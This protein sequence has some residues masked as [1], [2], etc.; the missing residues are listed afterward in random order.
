MHCAKIDTRKP[1]L[2]KQLT[3]TISMETFY[4]E[5]AVDHVF[6]TTEKDTRREQRFAFLR[7]VRA[8][9]A[10]VLGVKRADWMCD[11][12]AGK[13]LRESARERGTNV[14]TEQRNWKSRCKKLAA[15]PVLRAIASRPFWPLDSS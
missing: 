4:V 11:I 2:G 7:V 15:D 10:R 14:S 12:A 8:H 1:D 5:V 13:S 9:I 3:I 6:G